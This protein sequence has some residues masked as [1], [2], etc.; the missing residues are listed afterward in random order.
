MGCSFF[1]AMFCFYVLL[2]IFMN[3]EI[4]KGLFLSMLYH[5]YNLYIIICYHYIYLSII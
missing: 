5:S 3:I 1:V 2:Y 4:L